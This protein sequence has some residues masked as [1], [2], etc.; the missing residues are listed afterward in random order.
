MRAIWLGIACVCLVACQTNTQIS[1][2]RPD[3]APIEGE[4][5]PLAPFVSQAVVSERRAQINECLVEQDL[6]PL[7]E[8]LGSGTAPLEDEEARTFRRC[9]ARSS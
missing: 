1:V 7:A 5:E 4:F 6:P 3:L 8:G 9:I 2:P